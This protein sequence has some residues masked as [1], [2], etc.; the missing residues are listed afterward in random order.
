MDLAFLFVISGL[1]WIQSWHLL[2]AYDSPRTL[3][4]IGAATAVT[5]FGVVLFQDKLPMAVAAPA[6]LGDFLDPRTAISVL[7]LAWAAY[8]A[9]VAGVYLWGFDTRSLGYY[10]L[11]L[12]VVSLL[13]AVY[14]FIGDKL[15]ANGDIVQYSWLMGVIAV[16]LAVLAAL[17][18]FYLSFRP[19]GQAE[20][21]SHP[22]RT[23][24]GWFYLVFSMAIVVL[25]GLLVL[26]I[27]PLL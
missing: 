20:P 19:R 11:F 25:A 7:V 9:L 3:G 23:V 22:M 14:F 27:D 5:L 12:G 15:L 18:F 24:T 16:L 1:L 21:A 26:G 13:Y 2:G 6:D 4:M 10:G 17:L 8:A